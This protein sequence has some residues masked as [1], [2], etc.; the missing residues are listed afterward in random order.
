MKPLSK[1]IFSATAA[2]LVIAL[3]SFQSNSIAVPAKPLVKLPLA[4]LTSAHGFK[5]TCTA[6]GAVKGD[7]HKQIASL[8]NRQLQA[9]VICKDVALLKQTISWATSSFKQLNSNSSMGSNLATDLAINAWI[10]LQLNYMQRELSA[11]R[12]ELQNLS[13]AK[14]SKADSLQLRPQTWQLDLDGNGIVEPW[15][16]KF[17]AL[18]NRSNSTSFALSMPSESADIQTN[19]LIKTDASD[20]LWALS[21]HQFI[22]G[23]VAIVQAHTLNFRDEANRTKQGW[24][25]LDDKAAWQRAHGLIAQGM[26]TSLALRESILAETDND[27][28]WIPNPK[29]SNSAFPMVLEQADFDTWKLML[30]EVRKLWLGQTL[31]MPNKLAAGLL[32]ENAR[33]CENGTG[34]DIP[35]LFT[36]NPPNSIINIQEYSGAC[37]PVTSQRAASMLPE[38]VE[39][40]RQNTTPGDRMVRYMYWIN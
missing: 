33:W 11:S 12:K 3:G 14:L 21:Y 34:L 32:G 29:Q 35:K 30:G 13:R 26:T 36:T 18:P 31:L 19:T 8:S 1:I 5:T 17:F 16:A 9:W 38:M 23:I 39:Q 2:A 15:E 6:L 40:R 7:D 4:E 10:K 24:I 25:T 37:S 20:I 28:E 22:E 27:G